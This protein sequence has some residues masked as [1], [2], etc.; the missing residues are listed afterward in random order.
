VF[1]PA[2]EVGPGHA[3]RCIRL[4]VVAQ[5]RRASGAAALTPVL[6]QREREENR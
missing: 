2:Y 4:D 3:A 5:A 1:P 6:S